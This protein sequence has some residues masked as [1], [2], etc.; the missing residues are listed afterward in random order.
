ML[1]GYCWL[2]HKI[3]NIRKAKQPAFRQE[4]D[5]FWVN[6]THKLVVIGLIY[7][8]ISSLLAN[9]LSYSW[10]KISGLYIWQL[11]SI[12]THWTDSFHQ[13]Y[14]AR[15]WYRRWEFEKYQ[16]L[17]A[18]PNAL[19]LGLWNSKNI[20]AIIHVSLEAKVSPFQQISSLWKLLFSSQTVDQPDSAQSQ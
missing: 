12:S 9:C 20:P 8:N 3:Y 7:G 10:G 2:P 4:N 14:K 19:T 13:Y 17:G 11:A 15:L 1:N 16:G 5:S 6:I 18:A